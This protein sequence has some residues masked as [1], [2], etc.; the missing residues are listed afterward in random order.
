MSLDHP[1]CQGLAFSYGVFP[2][3]RGAATVDWH[4]FAEAWVAAHELP[5]TLAMLVAG[6]S[7]HSPAAND[8]VE[9]MCVGSEG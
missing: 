2:V 3:E 5:G 8:R 1:S 4:Q 6:P 9:F 7:T